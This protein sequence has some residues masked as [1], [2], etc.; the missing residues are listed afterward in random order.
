MVVTTQ[1]QHDFPPRAKPEKSTR[2]PQEGKR[3]GERLRRDKRE[4][5]SER[6]REPERNREGSS[7][8]VEKEKRV[9]RKRIEREQNFCREESK[10]NRQSTLARIEVWRWDSQVPH[11]SSH[12]YGGITRTARS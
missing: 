4:R 12:I 9:S 3:V 8:P 1:L 10:E 11:A 6:R 7:G 5:E 2:E